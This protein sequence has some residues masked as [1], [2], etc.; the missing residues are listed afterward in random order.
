MISC[1][2]FRSGAFCLYHAENRKPRAPGQAH[3]NVN[4]LNQI[5][6][7]HGIT[8]IYR[9]YCS[10]IF[11]TFGI[12]KQ[13]IEKRKPLDSNEQKKRAPPQRSPL[14]RFAIVSISAFVNHLLRNGV[15]VKQ[16][17]VDVFLALNRF[18]ALQPLNHFGDIRPL[19]RVAFHVQ[20]NPPLQAVGQP[21][22]RCVKGDHDHAVVRI[23]LET[24]LFHGVDGA[25]RLA[26]IFAVDDVDILRFL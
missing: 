18:A 12:K 17:F 6:H 5:T 8:G 25:E 26:V 3:K 7:R 11:R 23:A 10:V 15:A 13:R 20:R 1:A 14:I 22:A 21:Q 19:Q 24:R 4:Q 9:F 16:R 2:L